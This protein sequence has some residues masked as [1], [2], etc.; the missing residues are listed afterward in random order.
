MLS[1]L[2]VHTRAILTQ[3]TVLNESQEAHVLLLTN[4]DIG[5]QLYLSHCGGRLQLSLHREG[6]AS[7]IKK[8]DIK[9]LISSLIH[10]SIMCG[11]TP[12]FNS[13]MPLGVD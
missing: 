1:A 13:E 6:K 12:F 5:Q 10:L 8:L 9:F 2:Q 11:L 7:L 3:H 4:F